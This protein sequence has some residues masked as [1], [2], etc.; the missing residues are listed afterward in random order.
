MHIIG[1]IIATVLIVYEWI[2]VA[3]VVLSFIEAF[4]PRWSP[5]GA[6]LVV[7]E[8]IYTV[9]D[10]PIKLLRRFIRPLRLGNVALDLAVLV[11]FLII[12]VLMRVNNLLFF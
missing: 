1:S 2:L 8:A 6:G 10:P 9:T 11:L 5:R 3:R 12:M 4:N 7:C